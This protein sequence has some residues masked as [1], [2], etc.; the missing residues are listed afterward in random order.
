MFRNRII[1]S[2]APSRNMTSMMDRKRT[3]KAMMAVAK[4]DSDNNSGIDLRSRNIATENEMPIA[5]Q[6]N[7]RKQV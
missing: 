5:L 7:T 3:I 6:M 2:T 4:A 1:V